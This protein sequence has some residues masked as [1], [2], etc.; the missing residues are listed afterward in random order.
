MDAWWRR[1]PVNELKK[2]KS[3]DRVLILKKKPD[4]EA[5]DTFGHKTKQLFQVDTRLHG[6]LDEQT[7]LWYFKYDNASLPEPLK[8]RFT[9]FTKLYNY[10]KE[11]FDKRNIDIVEVQD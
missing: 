5:I 11:Y 9:T 8:P 2:N 3:N 7:C 4:K 6:I 1:C 10:A